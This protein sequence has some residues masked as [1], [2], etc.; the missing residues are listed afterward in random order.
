MNE[1]QT[2]GWAQNY[3]LLIEKCGAVFLCIEDGSVLFRAAPNESTCRLYPFAC[4]EKNIWLAIKSEREKQKA[5]MWELPEPVA[6][7]NAI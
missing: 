7:Q 5:S 3:K 1:E 2:A 4:T 6:E